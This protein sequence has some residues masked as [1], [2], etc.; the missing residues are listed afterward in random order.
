[1]SPE[2]LAEVLDKRYGQLGMAITADA[3]WKIIVLSRGLPTYT[4]RLGKHAAFRA[5]D[6]RKLKIDEAD[7]DFAI[8]EMLQGSL[9]SL[10]EKYDEATASNQPGNLFRQVLLACALA[11][12]DDNGYFKPAAIAEPLSGLVGRQMTIAN[13]QNHLTA[14]M[15]ED[16]G[17]ILQRI[18]AERAYM[19]RF[20]DPAMLPYVLMK[21][22]RAGLIGGDIKSVL[23]YP[24]QRE[25]FSNE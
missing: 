15:S 24:E 6:L 12:A 1:M 7:V 13:Y 19:F 2:E 17:R 23:S 25:L 5:V 10:R 3:K 18:G 14:F 20:R 16:R 11:R 4:H 8:D 9:Q 21:G 22:L